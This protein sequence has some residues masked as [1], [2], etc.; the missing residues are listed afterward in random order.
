MNDIIEA[1]IIIT[2]YNASERLFL[3]LLSLK[4]QDYPQKYYE[5]IVVD[6]GSTDN[7]KEMLAK[8]YSDPLFK[9]V[10][11]EKNRGIAN[12][13]NQGILKA[14]GKI[15]IFHDSDMIAT[16]NFVRRHIESH[17]EE[18]MV[19]CGLPWKS[20]Y[21]YFYKNFTPLQIA[22]FKE[23][24][25]NDQL[26]SK[27]KGRHKYQLI[28]QQHIIDQ[29]FLKYSF[30][31]T[32]HQPYYRELRKIIKKYSHNLNG[33]HFP[34]LFFLTKNVS[35]NR[36]RVL[37]VGLF[38]EN[39]VKYGYEDQDLGYR[40][41]KSGCRYKL[42]YNIISVHQEHPLNYSEDFL[43][44]DD[45]KDNC[46]Y[47]CEKYNRIDSIDL[48]LMNSPFIK[49]QNEIMNDIKRIYNHKRDFEILNIFLILLQTRRKN[50]I[51]QNAKIK[52]EVDID[53]NKIL[54]QIRELKEKYGCFHFT[55]TLL[56]LI[57]HFY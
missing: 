44:S 27:F 43:F 50:F 57:K 41:Y 13:R 11:V 22:L 6:N 37:D 24:R 38:D 56:S 40:L 26:I 32:K 20:I 5:A 35:A 33:F 2:S 55:G 29:S 39:I 28:K 30:N 31:H 53:F 21:S 42:N 1:S 23:Y 34:C 10:R 36:E 51:N 14:T 46:N 52:P 18:N 48:I 9:F 7:T 25:K 4:Y 47:V 8:F 17:R 12:G 54:S 49:K 19:I 16:K 45:Y 3:S 15:L